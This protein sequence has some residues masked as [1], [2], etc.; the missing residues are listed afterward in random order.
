MKNFEDRD[1][2]P[3]KKKHNIKDNECLKLFKKW[4]KSIEL[5]APQYYSSKNM[6]VEPW[7][8]SEYSFE[9]N[10]HSRIST[11]MIGIAILTFYVLGLM[12][13]YDIMYSIETNCPTVISYI[14]IGI[15]LLI[16]SLLFIPSMVFCM[17][18]PYHIDNYNLILSTERTVPR[19]ILLKRLWEFM[20]KNIFNPQKIGSYSYID[21]EPIWADMPKGYTSF[22]THR[23]ID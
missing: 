8:F 10:E 15:Y 18:V 3:W 6:C 16:V 14:L 21:S 17:T 23:N 19:R 22:F 4:L 20:K 5:Q 13:G 12:V 9:Y 11:T 1:I 7:R 2:R